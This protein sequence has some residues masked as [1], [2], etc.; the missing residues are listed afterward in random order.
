MK[1][2]IDDLPEMRV[3]EW[4]VLTKTLSLFLR[5]AGVLLLIAVIIALP[6]EAF[7]NY[8]FVP[9]YEVELFPA[10]T[11]EP[12]VSLLFMS[13]LT[14]VVAYYLIA[15][16]RNEKVSIL[17]SYLWGIRKW[18]R[19]IMYSFLQGVIVSAGFI[20]L[21][22]P[23]ILMSIRLMML[24]IV[25]SVEN[26]SVMNPL[27]VS[28]NMSVGRFWK[29]LGC[30]ILIMGAIMAFMWVALMGLD[31]IIPEHWIMMTVYD[32]LFDWL[33]LLFTVLLVVIYLKLKTEAKD[34]AE[35]ENDNK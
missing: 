16:L 23:G 15:K 4:G 25:V 13:V 32:V 28:W 18:P 33:Y 5:N 35:A 22:V 8:F 20:L 12:L 27:E 17:Q 6:V 34:A 10:L 1:S 2:A 21:I 24:P 30:A 14:P 26:T 9:E 29:M 7:K 11:R 3:S 19:M 31:Y